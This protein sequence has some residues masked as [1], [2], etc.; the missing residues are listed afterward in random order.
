VK[1]GRIQNSEEK[2]S[3]IA[4]LLQPRERLIEFSRVLQGT[5]LENKYTRCVAR[6]TVEPILTLNRRSRDVI[7]SYLALSVR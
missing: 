7:V 6:A 2:K 5:V 3:A 1:K 4:H